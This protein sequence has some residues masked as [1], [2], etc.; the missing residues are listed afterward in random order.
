[1]YSWFNSRNTA[2]FSHHFLI[3]D[4]LT[5]EKSET[6]VKQQ[7]SR[8]K[9]K[10][11]KR[12]DIIKAAVREFKS[13]GFYAT[14][15]DQISATARVSKR[16]LYNHFSSKEILFKFIISDMLTQI[17][18][19]LDLKYNPEAPIR[20]QLQK[21]AE[22]EMALISSEE[23]LDISRMAMAESVRAPE[24]TGEIVNELEACEWGMVPWITAAWEN[25]KLTISE[26]ELAAGQFLGLIKTFAFYPQVFYGKAPLEKEEQEKV[27]SSAVN[28]F[29]SNYVVS[30]I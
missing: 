27:I 28:L 3:P 26:P 18:S 10:S 12:A 5:E 13:R 1:M 2:V 29:V 4:P 17:Q 8:K 7:D 24:L 25:G 19:A 23:F 22:N 30:D 15:M 16:T 20:Y 6:P 9:L 21:I 11:K 14:S